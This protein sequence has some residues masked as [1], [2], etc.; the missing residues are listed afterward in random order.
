MR[1]IEA[2]PGML[3][4]RPVV[5]LPDGTII[6]GNMR[7]RACKE[8]GR[9]T[10][11]AVRV[12]LD[13]ERAKLWLLRDNNEYGEWEDEALAT[14]LAELQAADVD[15]DLSGFGADAIDALLASLEPAEIEDQGAKLAALKVSIA[16]PEHVVEP[17]DHWLLY[18]NARPA[19]SLFIES[20]YSGFAA[21][22]GHVGPEDLFVPYPSP[23]V[24]L[25][26]RARERRLVM[27]Q[28]DAWLAGHLLDKYAQV[29]GPESVRKHSTKVGV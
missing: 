14:L 27:V 5:A 12:D 15:L 3:Y 17:H 10:V 11:P 26:E 22:S 19:H 7:W 9:A 1:S 2:E 28:P 23:I 18:Q 20:V 29:H 21:F 16:D 6:A 25:T 8:L 24:P 13:D 4:A